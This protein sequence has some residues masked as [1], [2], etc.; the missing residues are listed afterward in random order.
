MQTKNCFE[1]KFKMELS[2]VVEVSQLID[3]I[4]EC[5]NIE[6]QI[7]VRVDYQTNYFK[8]EIEI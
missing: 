5:E 6:V 8:K 4:K 3:F 2:G 1:E 7:E